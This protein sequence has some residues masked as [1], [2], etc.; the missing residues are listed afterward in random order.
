MSKNHKPF[1]TVAAATV[2]AGTAV[3]TVQT[4][5]GQAAPAAVARPVVEADRPVFQ[6]PF[7]CDTKAYFGT[8]GSH[9]PAQDIYRNPFNDTAGEEVVASAP[10]TVNFSGWDSGGGWVVQ[11]DHGKG[12]FTTQI[13]LAKEQL[14]KQGAK[15][16]RGQVI[17]LAS[18]TGSKSGGINHVHYEQAY[19]VDGD[20]QVQWGGPNNERQT[21]TFDG[22]RYEDTTG[23]EIFVTSANCRASGP[24]RGIGVFRPSAKA[25]FAPGRTLRQSWGEK[26]DQPLVG[27]WNG[28]GEPGLA[29]FRPSA[30]TWYTPGSTWMKNWGNP[31]DLAVGGDFNGDGKD[32]PAV[33]RPSTK[34]WYTPG[35]VLKA[36]WGEPKDVPFAGDFDGDGKDEIGV[37]RP[38]TN[39]WY[40]PG[41]VLKANWGRSGDKPVIGDFNGDGKDEIGMF[42][43]STKSWYTPGRIMRQDWGEAGDLPIA[44]L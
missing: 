36:N 26:D 40:T 5:S 32:E 44:G 43:A 34:T 7:K 11:I 21:V 10:G 16:N 17:G 23:Q 25:W 14:I 37:Y 1:V 28:D 4:T 35:K 24:S 12:W 39:T 33:F 30:Q 27:D 31:G 13:H 42:R 19:D 15:V 3:V 20:G 6:L 41:K 8:A 38:S 18:D 9:A 2:L 22:I 29:I